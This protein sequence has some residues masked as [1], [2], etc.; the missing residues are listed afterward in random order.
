M[1]P[2]SFDSLLNACIRSARL[3]LPEFFAK[4]PTY[5]QASDRAKALLTERAAER[6][7]F[8]R[9]RIA[10][11]VSDNR[12][13]DL[14]DRVQAR[15]A[16]LIKRMSERAEGMLDRFLPKVDQ[17]AIDKRVTD[18][19]AKLVAGVERVAR[20]NAEQ[21][22]A[23]LKAID[24]GSKGEENKWFRTLVADVNSAAM[25]EVTDAEVNKMVNKL[26]DSSRL[27]ASNV[28][29]LSQRITKRQ[30]AIR[31][32]VRN[33]IRHLPKVR[34]RNAPRSVVTA[35]RCSRSS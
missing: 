30:E 19:V 23:I 9:G 16:A 11:I 20:R 26:R 34:L 32:R 8:W 15:R 17:S 35:T 14:A 31:E 6:E 24:D 29:K 4:Y 33:A 22:K 3:E 18:Y 27:L 10:A 1:T 28:Q 13:K 2:G 25:A 7:A 21:W 12:L 5:A